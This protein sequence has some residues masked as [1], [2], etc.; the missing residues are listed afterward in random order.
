[1]FKI[2]IFGAKSIALG[3]CLAVQKLHSD[4]EIVGFLVS[5]K[6][7]NPDTLAGLPVYELGAF[8]DKKICV[9]IAVPED[10]QEEVVALLEGQG[11]HNHICMDSEKESELMENYYA[12]LGVFQSIHGL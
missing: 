8:M 12:D 1:M 2:A 7:E 10:V 6:K 11:F 4:F 3:V 5:S 9:L